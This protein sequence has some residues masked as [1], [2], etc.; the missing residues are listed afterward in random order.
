MKNSKPKSYAAAVGRPVSRPAATSTYCV[1]DVEPVEPEPEEPTYNGPF[2][3]AS[4]GREMFRGALYKFRDDPTSGLEGV[5]RRP[6][7]AQLAAM[8]PLERVTYDGEYLKHVAE[9]TPEICI[10]ACSENSDALY[11]VKEQTPEI[12]FAAFGRLTTEWGRCVLDVTGRLLAAVKDQTPEICLA[13]MA[14]DIRAFRY[15]RDPTP[16]VALTAVKYCGKMLNYMKYKYRTFDVCVAACRQNLYAMRYVPPHMARAVERTVK[17]V[18]PCDCSCRG[19]CS[20]MFHFLH[21]N[22]TISS[23]AY[24][25]EFAHRNER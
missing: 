17:R 19:C 6:T 14:I 2:V 18:W 22:T 23:D 13:A 4:R 15:V 5:P 10:A 21:H 8:T 24:A 9:Q 20:K 12:C 11:Y 3:S 25:Y 7:P 1:R 16:E